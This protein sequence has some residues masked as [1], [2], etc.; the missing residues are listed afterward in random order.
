MK[1]FKYF[2]P[3]F[4]IMI[5]I[6][7]FSHQTGH[8]SSGL[9]SYIV[10]WIQNHLSITLPELIIR[11]IAHMSE[12][13]ILA[14][15]FFYGFYKNQFSINKTYIYSLLCSSLYACSDEFHQLFI[16][17]RACSLIDVFIDTIGAIIILFI[18]K[19]IMHSK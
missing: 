12:Y 4:L 2:I 18:L 1:K 11:K 19:K 17:G 7:Y 16:A 9:S 6:F 14:V 3:A 13:A 5:F 15:A 10:L 8:E